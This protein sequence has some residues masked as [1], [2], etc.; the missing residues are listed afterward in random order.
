[1]KARADQIGWVLAAALGGVMLASGFQSTGDKIAVVDLVQV[2]T[3][4]NIGIGNAAQFNKLKQARQDLLQFVEQNPVITTEQAQQL[5]DLIIK[6]NPTDADKASITTIETAIAA[7]TKASQ[8]LAAKGTLTTE[9]TTQLNEYRHRADVMNTTE[10]RWYTEFMNSLQDWSD[11]HRL[12]NLN[13][14]REAVSTV[15][16]AQAF[17]I[18]FDKGVAPYGANDLTDAALQAMNAQ[19]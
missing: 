7:T 10:E 12:D 2:A 19:K 5:H 13:K 18:V 17:T 3:K 9:E 1:M 11:S 14:A 6:D 16:K 8:D 15:A 4:S